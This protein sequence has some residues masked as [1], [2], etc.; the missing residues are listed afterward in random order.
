MIFSAT[1]AYPYVDRDRATAALRGQL[2]ETVA[3]AGAGVPA[4][5]TLVVDRP[6]ESVGLH[7]RAWFFWT[8]TVEPVRPLRSGTPGGAHWIRSAPEG[9]VVD[10]QAH[11]CDLGEILEVV[12]PAQEPPAA[13]QE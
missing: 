10:V 9:R 7:G 2:R 4:W 11:T 3:E 5:S 13:L 8:A 1:A 6:T 12:A